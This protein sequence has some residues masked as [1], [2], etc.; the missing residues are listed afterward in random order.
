MFFIRHETGEC[1]LIDAE[2]IPQRRR[3]QSA[4][5]YFFIKYIW[6]SGILEA[7]VESQIRSQTVD[8]VGR[9]THS[10]YLSQ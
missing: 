6:C 4:V 3:Q 9:D 1:A 7:A 2:R 10:Q 8:T 5:K